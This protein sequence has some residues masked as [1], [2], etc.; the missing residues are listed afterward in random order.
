MANELDEL[1]ESLINKE[2]RD[3]HVIEKQIPV[4]VGAGSTVFQILL[5]VFGIIPGLI[6]LAMKI[7]AR[8]YLRG[9]QQKIQANASQIDNYIEQRVIILQNA[10]ALLDKAVDLDK[11]VLTKVAQYRGGGRPESDAAR[12]EVGTAIE[13]V[14]RQINVAFE[15]YPD[16]K[17]HK[18]IADAMQQNSYLQREI[19]AAREVYNDTVLLWNQEIFK[20]P[21]KMIVAA[22]AGY[23]SRIPFSTS[24]EFKDRNRN[25]VFFK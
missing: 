13:N 24:Q 7:K 18:E 14:S 8:N 11:D 10:A 6:F 21:T 15:A 5:W 2:G 3:T 23:T 19:T 9:L 22:K 12:S 4:K 16:I 17:A 1:D 20:W 25:E